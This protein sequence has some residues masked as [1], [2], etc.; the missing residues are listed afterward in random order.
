MTLLMTRRPWRLFCYFVVVDFRYFPSVTTTV[1]IWRPPPRPYVSWLI[2]VK[3][4]V[5]DVPDIGYK[6]RRHCDQHP[7]KSFQC[8]AE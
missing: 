7:E 8:F 4:N 5:G 1:L 6:V 2:L 3:R